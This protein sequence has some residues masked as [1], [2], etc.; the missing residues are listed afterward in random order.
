MEV[1]ESNEAAVYQYIVK[2][3][4]PN[5]TD[6]IINFVDVFKKHE[7]SYLCDVLIDGRPYKKLYATL[8]GK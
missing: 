5:R 1:N 7:G 2:A 4:K 6:S 8:I 3:E